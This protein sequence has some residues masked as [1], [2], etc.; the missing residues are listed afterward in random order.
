MRVEFTRGTHAP[1]YADEWQSIH[2]MTRRSLRRCPLPNPQTAA[3]LRRPP[4][5]NY[6]MKGA[7]GLK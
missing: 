5:C 1:Q 4:E 2:S 6:Q 3:G 7:D